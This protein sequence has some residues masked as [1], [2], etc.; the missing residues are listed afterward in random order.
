MVGLWL[1]AMICRGSASDGYG[2]WRAC[3]VALRFRSQLSARVGAPFLSGIIG[4]DGQ[5][6]FEKTLP[7]HAVFQSTG[8]ASLRRE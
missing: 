7:C 2:S 6:V 4:V 5:R 1:G 3:C 8:V